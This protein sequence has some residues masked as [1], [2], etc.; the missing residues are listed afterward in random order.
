MFNIFKLD[1]IL[2]PLAILRMQQ[3]NGVIRRTVYVFGVRIITWTV[4]SK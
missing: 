4:D 1:C 3:P 2:I